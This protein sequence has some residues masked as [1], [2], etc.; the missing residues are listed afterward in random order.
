MCVFHFYEN[1]RVSFN[2]TTNRRKQFNAFHTQLTVSTVSEVTGLSL[3]CANQAQVYCCQK[4]KTPGTY[5][6]ILHEA[7][8]PGVVQVGR[9]AIQTN[10]V[11]VM[12]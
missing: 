4:K 1:I 7:K 8:R 6:L 2:V 9:K 11:Y 3:S 10:R 12:S 5:R